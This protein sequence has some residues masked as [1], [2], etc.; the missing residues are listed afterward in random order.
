VSANSN[1]AINVGDFQGTWSRE[2]AAW[3]HLLGF[4]VRYTHLSQG[5]RATIV[6]TGTVIDLNSAHNLNAFGPSFSLQTKRRCG[7]TGFA[8]YGQLHG[9]ILFGQADEAYT[10]LNNGVLQQFS[11]GQTDVL[12]A[13]EMEVGGEYQRS[14]GRVNLFLQAGFV[15]QVWWGGGNASNLDPLGPASA[16]NHNFGFLGLALRAGVRY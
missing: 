4:G 16:T 2:T 11:R 6:N 1:L 10:A 13:G 14:I 12:P 7:E 8:V 9:A 3:T 5:Y 15:G